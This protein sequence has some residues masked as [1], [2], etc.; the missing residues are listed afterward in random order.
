MLKVDSYEVCK[1]IKQNKEPS[2]TKVLF[3]I[4]KSKEF[5]NTIEKGYNFVQQNN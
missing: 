3:L 1:F 5:R 4:T 2:E